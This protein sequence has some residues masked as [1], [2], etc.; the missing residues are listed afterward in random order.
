MKSTM[1]FSV[2]LL[3]ALLSSAPALRAQSPG[4]QAGDPAPPK[5]AELARD[6][7][8]PPAEWK[9]RPLWFW[10][11]PLDRAR[12]TEIME[13]SVTSGYHGFGIL[14]TKD[15]GVPF[16]SPAYLEHYKHAVETAARLGQKMCLYDEFWFPS[17]SA[18][19]L[20]RERYPEALGKRL[21]LVE[22]HATGP[23]T[24]NLAVPAGELMAAVAMNVATFERLDLSNHSRDGR[25]SWPAPT[26]DWR[27]ML[28]L[29]VPDGSGNLVDYL[30]PDAV[31]KFVSL[32]YEHYH[33]TFPEH[34]GKTIDSAF[35]DEPTFHWIQGGRAWTPGFN[36]EFERRHGRSPAL[37][38]PALWHEIGPDTAA[39]RNLLFGMRTELF[40]KGF[41]K[42]LA[43]WCHA[44]GI[45]LTGHVD[46]EEIV[47]PVGLCGDLIKVF[48][49][50]PIPGLDQIFAYDRGSRMYKVVSSAA[51]NYGRRRVM[52][53]CYGAMDLPVAN[54]Y[55]EAMD[56]F[57]KGVNLMVP[58]AVWYRTNPITFPPELSWRTEPYASALPAYND[59]IGRLQRVLQQGRPV[60]D[61]AVLYPIAGLQAAYRFGVG[62][63]YEGGLIPE[64]ADYMAVGE[65]LSLDLR[66]DF[67]YLHPETLDARCH[68]QGDIVRLEH[69]EIPQDYRVL[70]LPGTT[71][72]SDANL[73]KVKQFFEAGGRVIATTRL[74]DQSVEWDRAEAVR[75]GVR[76]VFGPD[77][78]TPPPEP[79]AYPRATASTA[80]EGGG[81]AANLAC[82]GDPATRWNARD[83]NRTDQWIEVDL[84]TPRPFDRVRI[85][86]AFDRAQSH[87]VEIWDGQAWQARAKGEA[88]GTN[89]L[90]PLGPV[91]ASRVRL[92]IESVNS[93]T[94]S[95]AEFEVLDAQGNNLAARPKPPGRLTVNRNHR[96]GAAW[97]VETP[98]AATL[99]RVLAEA[100]PSPDV[101]WPEPPRVRGGHLTYLHKHIAGREFFFFANSSDTPVKT[102]VLLRGRLR[103]ERW[104]PH[105]GRIAPQPSELE[106]NASRLI[107]DLPPVSSVFLVTVDSP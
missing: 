15:M 44:R 88:I 51:V 12:T 77:A 59:Y 40:S 57:A 85:E 71:T 78:V 56:Q 32:T 2:A 84:G 87:R 81:H 49:Y 69:P 65:R 46:Q 13:Q 16:M 89:R 27:V 1:T 21:D 97:F 91:T 68:V 42:T 3:L 26:G 67:T 96:G 9:S 94:P 83:G 14:P 50:Q 72:L 41:V 33:Q 45:Q 86:E 17:G 102:P 6:F 58:H 47:N 54:L 18:G 60:V 101:S 43:D 106:D 39:A 4:L 35:Y 55:R 73:A 107:L 104:D 75:Q 92:V 100:L 29:C 20:L 28:F 103:L 64:W 24:V 105:T 25:L 76:H 48:E 19:G 62:K 23:A 93:D 34:F 80:W 82:D 38:Y 7:A 8:Q 10:N 74:P 95:I 22:T 90:H 53:E 63:P 61:I 31:K 30:D 36:R 52:T 98:D 70:V 79:P 99:A 5:P 37:L 66:Q 11:G